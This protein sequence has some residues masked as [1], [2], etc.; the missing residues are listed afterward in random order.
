M[1]N[2]ERTDY[3]RPSVLNPADYEEVAIWTT[4]IQG[5]GDAQFMLQER[6]RAKA[7]MART[8][9]QVHH[10]SN[11]SCGIC[12]NLLAIYLILFYHAK[13]NEYITV[14]C[15]CACKLGMGFD[16][17]GMSL[18]KKNLANARE[19]QAGK[20]KAIAILSANGLIDAWELYTTEYPKH[21]EGCT[22]T[23]RDDCQGCYDSMYNNG[24]PTHPCTCDYFNR[25]K[26]FEQFPERTI[27]D[28]VGKL[29]KYGN[30]SPKQ[31]GFVQSLLKQIVERPIRLAKWQ[32]EKDAA[33]PVP[34]GRVT[35]RGEVIKVKD[36]E[37]ENRFGYSR[38]SRTADYI[39][40]T[41]IIVKLEN[42]SCV[43]GRQFDGHVKGDKVF[44]TATVE[45]SKD[46]PKFGFFKRAKAAKTTEEIAAEL[47]AKKKRIADAKFEKTVAWG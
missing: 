15:D 9:G 24:C 19:A 6:E 38:Y 18:F 46:D 28:I 40:I 2:K 31:M 4:N 10:Y 21:V 35:M 13:S 43:F 22:G 44:F 34:T 12:G 45:A 11:G 20:R 36:V 23:W 16:E 17:R 27:R 5:F 37:V 26:T 41:K 8:G 7:H 25:V 33:G 30:I 39:T 32:A 3:H 47:A 42:G 1:E 29:V 14:G